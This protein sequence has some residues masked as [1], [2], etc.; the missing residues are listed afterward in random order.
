MDLNAWLQ[1]LEGLHPKAIDLGLERVAQVRNILLP[2]LRIPVITVGGTNGKGSTC[3]YLEA[4]LSAAGYRTGLYTSPH[5]L[6]YNERVRIAQTEVGDASLCAAFTAIEA[7]RGQITLSYFEFGTLAAMWLFAQAAVDIAI[8]EVGLGGRLDAVNIFDADSAVIT[9]IDIDHTEYLGTSREQIAREKAG[10]FRAMRPA[11]CGDMDPP[12]ALQAEALR[13]GADWRAIGDRYR[14]Q[15]HAGGW[16]YRGTHTYLNLPLPLMRGDY[17]LANAA[18]AIAAL[19]SV[20]ADFPVTEGAIRQGLLSAQVPGRYQ[21]A[22]QNPQRILDVAHNPHG[23]NALARSLA[24]SPVS[25]KTYAVF[26]MLAD[27]DIAGVV[28]AMRDVV[29]V[30]LVAGLDVP[31]GATAGILHE[32]LTAAGI[33]DVSP[34]ESIAAAWIFACEHAREN[35]R[36]CVFGSF[37]TVAA[38]LRLIAG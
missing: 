9:S 30:W 1:Y 33:A 21:I 38:I 37:Y 16:D 14:Y 27:K 12:V 10:I 25:G 7:A 32:T 35:D 23:A 36:I 34:M 11:I 22:G 13:L 31:R 6:R 29:D 26:G 8:L 15:P 28:A 3:A 24:Q 17:Q 19:E 5:L 2:D 4:M 20:E 18:T